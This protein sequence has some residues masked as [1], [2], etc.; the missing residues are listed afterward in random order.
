V[1]S[2]DLNVIQVHSLLG[3]PGLNRQ[4]FFCSIGGFDTHTGQLPDQNRLFAVLDGAM[5]AFYNATVEMNLSSKVTTFTLSDFGRTLKEASGAGSDHAWGN[6]H[7][8]MGGAV[9]GGDLYGR[10][11]L[12]VLDGPDDAT[13]EGRWIPTT[14]LDQYAA[15]LALWFGVPLSGPGSINTIFPNLPNFSTPRL[16]FMG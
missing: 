16:G 8:I 13:G 4:I 6:H 11:P 7:V 2:S 14:A 15:T 3:N 10:F 5:G 9:Q 12:Q 1:C